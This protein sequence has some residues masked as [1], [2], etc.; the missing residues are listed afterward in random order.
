ML[1]LDSLS[2][3]KITGEDISGVSNQCLANQRTME[4]EDTNL[5][6]KIDWTQDVKAKLVSIPPPPA[7]SPPP[8]VH[9]LISTVDLE[10]PAIS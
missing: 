8:K 9:P 5:K 2:E 6:F 7:F 1:S 10:D 4:N 3:T